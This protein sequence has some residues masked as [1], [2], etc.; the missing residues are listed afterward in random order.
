MRSDEILV[1]VNPVDHLNA[2]GRAGIGANIVAQAKRLDRKVAKYG[3]YP[4][5][6][7]KTGQIPVDGFD[8]GLVRFNHSRNCGNSIAEPS[9]SVDF[10]YCC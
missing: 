9:E 2:G 4:R 7:P 5:L 10:N 6:S 1:E 3:T 8:L